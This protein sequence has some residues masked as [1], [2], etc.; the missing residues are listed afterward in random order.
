MKKYRVK[1]NCVMNGSVYF[2]SDILSPEEIK[3]INKL[4]DDYF[5]DGLLEDITTTK[6]TT[7]SGKIQQ[8]EQEN[9]D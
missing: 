4:V 3:M 9:Q 1:K 2:K 7:G 6:K 8:S 5:A